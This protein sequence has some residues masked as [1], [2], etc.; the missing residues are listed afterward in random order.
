MVH[1]KGAY[2][3]ALLTVVGLSACGDSNTADTLDIK[4]VE[5]EDFTYSAGYGSGCRFKV[6]LVNN[7][8]HHLSHIDAFV[9]DG[10]EYLFS[11]SGEV[12]VQGSSMRS[13]D[14]QKNKRCNEI[15]KELE[16]KKNSCSLGTLSEADCFARVQIVPPD[17]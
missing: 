10:E 15:G 1:F 12:P 4:I 5:K 16:L 3:T 2:F 6:Q 14:V 8:A 13:H 9:L 7:T 11:V 17:A